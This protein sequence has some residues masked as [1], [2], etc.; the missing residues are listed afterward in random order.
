M[1]TSHIIEC[2][3]CGQKLRIPSDK[4]LKV[5]CPACKYSFIANVKEEKE[6]TFIDRLYAAEK[7]PL[8]KEESFIIHDV[9]RNVDKSTDTDNLL[10]FMTEQ[11]YE[12]KQVRHFVQ[13]LYYY[14]YDSNTDDFSK[15]KVGRFDDDMNWNAVKE[16]IERRIRGYN[17]GLKDFTV[18]ILT[19]PY[20]YHEKE[21]DAK[22]GRLK[23]ITIQRLFYSIWISASW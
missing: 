18:T 11:I 15:V 4:N 19:T 12:N 1:E 14:Q 16:M 3:K 7:N 10:N 9:V 6:P 21:K 13:E 17:L 5:T 23:D 8:S 20:D 2:A 22:T